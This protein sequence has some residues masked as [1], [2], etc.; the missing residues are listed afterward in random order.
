MDTQTAVAMG[1]PPFA[2][3]YLRNR[4]I[5][6]AQSLTD[7]VHGCDTF[8]GSL[9]KAP[10][11]SGYAMLYCS[12][13]LADNTPQALEDCAVE[14][15]TRYRQPESTDSKTME[16]DPSGAVQVDRVRRRCSIPA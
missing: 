15:G 2:K 3:V 10:L 9:V 16:N 7:A 12:S 14:K 4:H 13:T 1:L 8:A 11:L 6:T 5:L